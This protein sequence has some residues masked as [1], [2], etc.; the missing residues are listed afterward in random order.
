MVVTKEPPLGPL[1][2]FFALHSRKPTIPHTRF[3]FA[4]RNLVCVR[5]REFEIACLCSI[6]LARKA[7][8]FPIFWQFPSNQEG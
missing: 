3:Q 2:L 4:T 6:R 5:P 1:I 7:S 8:M